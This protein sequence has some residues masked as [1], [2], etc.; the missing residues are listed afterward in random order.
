M[1]FLDQPYFYT[2]NPRIFLYALKFDLKFDVV[3][4]QWCCKV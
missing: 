1:I 4:G 2:A 3:I